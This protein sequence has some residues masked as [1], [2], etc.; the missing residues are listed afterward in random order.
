MKYILMSLGLL[1]LYI[2][3]YSQ[4]EAKIYANVIEEYIF[5]IRPPNIDYSE[6]STLI[7]LNRVRAL[8]S[9]D[10]EDYYWFKQRFQKLDKSTFSNFLI[11]NQS[12]RQFEKVDIT[13]VE[14][15]IYD[16]DSLPEYKYLVTKY[17]YWVYSILEFSNIGLNEEMNQAL[18]YYSFNSGSGVGGGFYLVYAKRR[19]KWKQVGFIPAWAS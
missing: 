18:V 1:S 4:V 3:A 11:E 13:N 12:Y 14:F 5:K 2:S 10:M 19:K 9:L 17:P 15:V 7:V 16:K 8:D 6:K